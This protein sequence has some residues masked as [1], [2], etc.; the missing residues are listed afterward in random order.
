MTDY[1]WQSRDGFSAPRPVYTQ[2]TGRQLLSAT[3]ALLRDDRE[4]L[5]LPVLGL[6]S[7]FFAAAVLFGP[8]FAIGWFAGGGQHGEWGIAVGAVFA[9]FAF[10][11]V[12]IYFQAALVVGAN[13]R[14]DGGTPTLSGVLAEAWT[15][16]VKI[17]SWAAL[18]TTVGV[19][20]RVIAERIGILG[21]VLRALG[22]VAWA[23]ASFFALP[24][25]IAENL[26]P[27]AAV[28]RSAALIREV[29]GTSLRTTLRVTVL[30][31]LGLVLSLGVVAIGVVAI[32][33]GTGAGVAVGS[34]LVVV[35]VVAVAALAI[36][37]SA[38]STYART[39]IYRYATGRS[40]P[41][42]DATLFAGVFRQK[43]GRRGIA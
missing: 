23:I 31:L 4:L 35:G 36:I 29:W 14:A 25:V 19:G 37:F 12:S 11:A 9:A 42:I 38:I 7:G 15:H 27:I 3:W 21:A 20:L 32:T 43:R 13:V 33:S 1:E 30:Q 5:W 10:S 26:G 24:V 40:V 8:G 41:G 16:W 2:P 22:G 34:I 6:I 28:K 17:L 18:T 39:L